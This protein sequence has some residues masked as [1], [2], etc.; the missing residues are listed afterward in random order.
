[1]FFKR[2]LART[3]TAHSQGPADAR[4]GASTLFLLPDFLF[5][6]TNAIVAY[7]RDLMNL[8]DWSEVRASLASSIRAALP[9]QLAHQAAGERVA[10]IAVNVDIDYGGAGLYLLPESDWRDLAPEQV[11]DLDQWPIST[12]WD[13]DDA[14]RAFDAHWGPWD[15]WYHDHFR[16]DEGPWKELYRGLIRCACEAL[17][18]V[19]A[20]GLFDVMAKTDG[21]QLLVGVTNESPQLTAQR[22]EQYRRTGA[23]RFREYDSSDDPDE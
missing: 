10:A 21:F 11:G 7:R 12:D 22:Y 9:L 1:V 18:E 8:P 13:V 19:E 17:R 20:E 16:W 14:S 3:S 23:I 15:K 4:Q 2:A 6:S 5:G